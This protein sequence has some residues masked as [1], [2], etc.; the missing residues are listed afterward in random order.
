M[1]RPDPTLAPSPPSSRSALLAGALLMGLIFLAYLSAVC[2]DFLW[3][4][5]MHVTANPTIV[6][7]QGLLEIWTTS[8]ANY[9]PLVLTNFWVQHALW[10]LNP[11][12]YHLVTLACHAAAAVILWRL[13]L[14]LRVPGAWW[15]AALWALHPVQVESVA[16]ICELKN[17][18]SAIF[19]LAAIW[20]W[21]GWLGLT[22][23]AATGGGTAAQAGGTRRDYVLALACA[24]AAILSKPSTVML[25][26]ALL[27]C[28]W[29]VRRRFGWRDLGPLVPF[30]ALSAVAA[31]WT[32]WE[33]KY[34]SGAIGEEWNQT[35]SERGIIAGHAI[36]FYLGK[37]LWPSPLIFIYPRWA[38]DAAD[39]LSY[40]PLGLAAVAGGVLWWKR[41]KVPAAF[42]AYGYFVALLF[43]VLGFFS[44][45]FFRYSFVG[46]HFQYLASMGP[47]VLI[48]AAAATYGPRVLPWAGS[49]TLA[50]LGALTAVQGT[51]YLSSA[52][53]WSATTARNPG[54]AMAW[55]QLGAVRA[56]EG[57]SSEAVESFQRALKLNPKHPEALNHLGLQ[58][59]NADRG[60]EAIT[61]FQ[62]AI[63]ARP[64]F[65]QAHA[66]LG[67]AFL[68][69]GRP[70]EALTEFAL[71][72]QAG[73]E[74][75]RMQLNQAKALSALGRPAE[76]LVL[77]EAVA[78]SNP[79]YPG[80][81]NGWGLALEG[82]NRPAEAIPHYEAALRARIDDP[83][84]REN[85]A[86][87]L[88]R[89]GRVEE[90]LKLFEQVLRT[91]TPLA[92]TLEAYGSALMQA[93]RLPEAATQ[94][95]RA[96]QL[97]PDSAS[98]HN[99][100]GIVLAQTGRPLEALKQFDEAIRLDPR[101]DAAQVNRGGALAVLNRLPEA[102]DAFA[103]A[104]QLN[105]DS[106]RAHGY[107][108]Q[109][110]QALG[111]DSEAREHAAR[112]EQL[113]RAP[114]PGTPR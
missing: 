109:I 68:R 27:L 67:T 6:G 105:P 43:P 88:L 111:R 83:N 23:T 16:W 36:W 28:A 25:P 29:W 95:E 17:T 84:V 75:L 40:L 19:F 76:A 93:G 50:V 107:L 60:D 11:L 44:V 64:N 65:P 101:D 15:G 49:A 86:Q 85:L 108:A 42:F 99:R 91:G 55:A 80:L 14:R 30:F 90:S 106:A 10:G 13:L 4:D 98:A 45:Y 20:F 110:L 72:Q 39:V 24:L 48:A 47:L 52:A 18:Q 87:S 97:Q 92:P 59:L 37:L 26:I 5:D 57:R 66:N 103:R 58:S 1:R 104:V 41:D 74:V 71:A 56:D 3:D 79:D 113:K 89:V 54:S 21:A 51:T 38:L 77:F 102:R 96:L 35:W 2:G 114:A 112:A 7:P 9:F 31:G 70:Q 46:D 61:Y 12:G 94:L 78:R 22:T 62:K 73:F 100:L 8:A 69:L 82:L 63:A 33:Q 81:Q 32:I 53:L 34:H